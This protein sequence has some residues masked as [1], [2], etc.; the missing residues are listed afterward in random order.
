VLG[1]VECVELALWQNVAPRTPHR[2]AANAPVVS[3]KAGGD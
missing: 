1:E 3:M 2:Q